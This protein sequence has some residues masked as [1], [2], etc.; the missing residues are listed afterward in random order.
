V[1]MTSHDALARGLETIKAVV[2]DVDGVL[3]DGGLW[4]G[5]SGEWKRFCFASIMGVSCAPDS[6][7]LWSQVKTVAVTAAPKILIRYVVKGCRDDSPPRLLRR[8]G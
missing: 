1:G 5:P 7:Q 2:L 3:S 4:W 6:S 8:G